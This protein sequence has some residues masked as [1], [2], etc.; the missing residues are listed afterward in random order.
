M[1]TRRIGSLEVSVVGL[2][3]NQLGT[4]CDE[5]RTAA[6]LDTAVDNGVT[7]LDTAD[8]YGAGA[9]EELLG[10]LLAARRDKVVIATKFGSTYGAAPGDGGASPR[11]ITAAVEASLRR[12]R[13]DRIDLYQLHFPD[14]T[15]PIEET[16]GALDV[17]VQAGKVRE[18]GCAN[19]GTAQIDEAARAAK[20]HGLR[21]FV[22][23]QNRLNL[24]RPEALADTVPA[25]SAHGMAFLPFFPLASGVLTGKYRRG[26]APP[27]GTRLGD[28]VAPD[29]V[30]KILSDRTHDRL[31][32]FEKLAGQD[33]HSLLE[34]SIA[35][36]IAQ[37]AVA[38]VIAGVTSPA[39]LLA[40]VA[41][42][43]WELSE[44]TAASVS[45]LAHG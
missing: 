5:A 26:Q 41:A 18:I 24:L 21:P 39:Q 42:A 4:T 16:L 2:G 34:L 38:S 13:T 6:I 19:V 37:P 23:V 10:R 43:E 25:A 8:E 32:A 14:P 20:D 9:S 29:V 7:F 15:V 44:D 40:N 35:W 12:L 3:C 33:G 30:G 22:S 1:R 27:E 28:H 17:L 36:L 31:D 11:W 45:A